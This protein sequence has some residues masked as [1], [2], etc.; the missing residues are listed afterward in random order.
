MTFGV[1]VQGPTIG[2]GTVDTGTFTVTLGQTPTNG[3]TL[4]LTY[5]GE[6]LDGTYNPV[7]TSILQTH[8]TWTPVKALPNGDVAY[9]DSEV[10]MGVV[11]ASGTP[12][13]TVTITIGATLGTTSLEI[14]YITEFPGGL[15][16]DQTASNPGSGPI[17][18]S[19]DSGTT[20]T[21]TVATEL[22]VAGI[23]AAAT[24][25]FVVAQSLPTNSFIIDATG[26]EQANGTALYCSL[27]FL[28][29]TVSA[30]GTQDAGVTFA[31]TPFWTGV[32]ATF[33]ASTPV[34]VAQVYGD[35]LT[36]YVC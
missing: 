10:W 18:S 30:T 5:L 31:S 14:A 13:T 15:T 2:T 11:D 36:S 4:L 24:T 27:S 21:T 17:S 7:I 19:G 35:G 33:Y 26:T 16:T 1:P 6:T 22:I 25:D 34:T 3:N 32:I 29:K 8:V 9:V 28:Y 12:G 23:G 20:S